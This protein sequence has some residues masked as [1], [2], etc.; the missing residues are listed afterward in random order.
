MWVKIWLQA[1]EHQGFIKLSR[2][3]S[4]VVFELRY[5]IEQI[6][7]YSK[8]IFSNE[9]EW[10]I[11]IILPLFDINFGSFASKRIFFP[12]FFVKLNGKKLFYFLFSFHFFTNLT[13]CHLVWGSIS[14]HVLS[15]YMLDWSIHDFASSLNW[16]STC[17]R[18]D[19]F[20]N[21]SV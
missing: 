20:S 1:F 11:I 17:E 6:D 7:P 8:E 16:P 14:T 3:A 12:I 21:Q 19:W 4:C 18:S 2:W 15:I 5:S 13:G 10:K 9:N